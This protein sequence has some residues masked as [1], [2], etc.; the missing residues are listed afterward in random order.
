M[1]YVENYGRQV[2]YR[3]EEGGKKV[4]VEL[5]GTGNTF[6]GGAVLDETAMAEQLETFTAEVLPPEEYGPRQLAEMKG[7]AN[8]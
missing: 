4:R 6:L 1:K 5:Y 8:A 3:P 7:E 2:R